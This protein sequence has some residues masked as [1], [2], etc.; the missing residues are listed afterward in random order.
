L[1]TDDV[2]DTE[3]PMTAKPAVSKDGETV[4][5]WI[6]GLITSGLPRDRF[7]TAGA[8]PDTVCDVLTE[9]L[10]LDGNSKQNL[11]TFCQTWESPQ[12]H[13]PAGRPVACPGRVG[14]LSGRLLPGP[15]PA[16]RSA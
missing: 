1:I 13:R 15:P 2:R 12:V 10:L 3:N 5:P 4:R 16:G 6:D 8:D 9:E 14:G 7:P 11:A